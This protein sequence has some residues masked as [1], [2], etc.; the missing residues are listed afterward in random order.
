[1]SGQLIGDALQMLCC[2]CIIVIVNKLE[3]VDN[4]S[5]F[6]TITLLDTVMG[7]YRYSHAHDCMARLEM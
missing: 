6:V 7:R 3:G 1:M 5:E 2:V 4:A